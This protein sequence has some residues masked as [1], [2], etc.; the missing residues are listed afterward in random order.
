MQSL[1]LSDAY[2][3]GWN[4]GNDLKHIMAN[5]FSCISF[6]G[7]LFQEWREGHIDN[8]QAWKSGNKL[9]PERFRN[10]PSVREIEQ[11][12]NV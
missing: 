7:K 4:A 3:A 5:P 2:K 11:N 1:V 10:V 12:S 9:T 6:N 8:A